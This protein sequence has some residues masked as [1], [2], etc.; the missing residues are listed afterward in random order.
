M[1]DRPPSTVY[2][3]PSNWLRSGIFS[4]LEKGAALTFNLGT[5][6]LLLRNLTKESFAA[7]GVFVIITYFVEMGR[8]GL[9]Q[10]AL[11]RHLALSRDDLKTYS[12][13]STA[14]FFLNFSFSVFSNLI[15][16]FGASWVARQ[17][18]VPQIA[19]L[20]PVY[21]LVNFVMALYSHGY[22]VQQANSEF[23]GVFWGAFFFRGLPFCCVF[24]CWLTGK[25]IELS[26]LAWAMLAGA[27]AGG[28]SVWLFARPFLFFSKKI[29]FQWVKKL[30]SFGKYVLGTNLSTMFYKN[31][32]KLTLG[33][34][35]GP[36]AFAVYDAAGKVTQMVEMPSFS[37]AAVVFPHS[38]ERMA[39][40]GAAGVKRLYERSVAAILAIIL[41]FLVLAILF[42]EP[43]IWLLA[44]EQY[45][46]SADVLRLTAFFG[47]FLP[48]AVQFGTVLDSTGR[49]ATNFIFTLFTALL[50]LG[51]SYWFVA[52]FGLFGAAFA[53]LFGYAASFILIQIYLF[54]IF[55]INALSAFRYVPEVYEMG[56]ELLK[57]KMARPAD[58]ERPND[59]MTQ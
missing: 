46:A 22:F 2:R 5:T 1:P 23:R 38:A 34:L 40:E 56:W 51:L 31:I 35:L 17:Y 16:W 39:R 7:W 27:L 47:L 54:K 3:S 12:A 14:S 26:H 24:F 28:F 32:D 59:L 13:I 50:N 11:M 25:S 52:K 8:S 57:K 49:P 15:L 45:M 41:P 29:D 55:K 36:A 44:G 18:Q 43:I 48:F 20:L 53:T 58:L 4:L 21:F 37:V 42:A 10:N 9:I 33:H 19:E 6:V 30:F